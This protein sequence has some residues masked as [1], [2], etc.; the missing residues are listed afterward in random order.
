MRRKPHSDSHGAA[1]IQLEGLV[2]EAI[3]GSLPRQKL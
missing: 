2:L 3:G 1:F